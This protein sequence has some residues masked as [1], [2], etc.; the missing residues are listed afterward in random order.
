MPPR[1]SPPCP[2]A[3]LLFLLLNQQGPAGDLLRASK[4]DTGWREDPEPLEACR[5]NSSIAGGWQQGGLLV[6]PPD[7]VGCEVHHRAATDCLDTL[8][9]RLLTA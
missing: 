8:T 3:I 7:Q 2:L 5:A 4:S 6:I 1:A 9:R